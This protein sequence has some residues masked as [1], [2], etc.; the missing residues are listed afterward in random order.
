MENLPED[1]QIVLTDTICI[2]SKVSI[3][4][5][6]NVN[7]FC[8]RISRKC[9][10]KNGLDRQ[11]K[12]NDIIIEGSLEVLKWAL[13]NGYIWNWTMSINAVSYGHVHILEWL[14]LNNYS[15][16][17]CLCWH[18]AYEGHLNVLKWAQ[19][20][21]YIDSCYYDVG[22]VAVINGHLEIVNWIKS[23]SDLW[24][25]HLE[26]FAKRHWPNEFS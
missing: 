7:K 2:S 14:R 18:A 22:Y 8:Y 13:S 6:A 16:S 9:V 25:L 15:M 1:L 23:N 17:N 21:K 20:V 10:V 26:S 24:D 3:K 11:L 4:V 19:S 5:L 12:L